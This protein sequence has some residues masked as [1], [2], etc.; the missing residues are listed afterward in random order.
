MKDDANKLNTNYDII[1]NNF[2]DLKKV[3]KGRKRVL[4]QGKA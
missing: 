3:V 2:E 4:N 1:H